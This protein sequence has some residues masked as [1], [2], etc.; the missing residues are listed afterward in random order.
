[1][2]ICSVDPALLLPSAR[3]HVGWRQPK[4]N[5]GLGNEGCQ[6]VVSY[7]VAPIRLS[8]A[9]LGK[10]YKHTLDFS[11]F[12]SFLNLPLFGVSELY[13]IS[14]SVMCNKILTWRFMVPSIFRFL[15]SYIWYSE[16]IHGCINYAFLG[17][18]VFCYGTWSYFT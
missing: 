3:D 13:P 1:M 17:V 5:V 10:L 2:I 4:N 16:T 14:A 7:C 6:N 18:W 11:V 9:A 12:S 15:D 8:A